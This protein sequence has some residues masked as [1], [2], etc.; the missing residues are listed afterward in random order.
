MQLQRQ[1]QQQIPCGDDNKKSKKL[2]Q[3]RKKGNCNN[4]KR[5]CNNKGREL[6]GTA[7]YWPGSGW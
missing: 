2:Q 5:N 3:Q 4:K 7:T 1:L 6:E